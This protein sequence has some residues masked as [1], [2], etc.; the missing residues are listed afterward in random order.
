MR[1]KIYTIII[2]YSLFIIFYQLLLSLQFYL[3]IFPLIP[4]HFFLFVFLS[5]IIINILFYD[6][7]SNKYTLHI[8][9]EMRFLSKRRLF[10]SWSRWM[11][12]WIWNSQ[13]QRT[14]C[15]V[16]QWNYYVRILHLVWQKMVILYIYT[17]QYVPFPSGENDS[18]NQK[19]SPPYQ[20]FINSIN[21]C[22]S[23]LYISIYSCR[24]FHFCCFIILSFC[25]KFLFL[26]N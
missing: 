25:F 3:I 14:H 12:G 5:F 18:Q 19:L 17:I 23:N 10:L 16:P 13:I 24:L 21:M 20:L 15:Q 8:R 7:W 9:I 2:L 1:T 11:D 22:I 6:C 4:Y 26:C